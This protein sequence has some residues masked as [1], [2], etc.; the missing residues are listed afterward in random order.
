M[1]SAKATPKRRA[2]VITRLPHKLR[3][4]VHRARGVEAADGNRTLETVRSPAQEFALSGGG[5]DVQGGDRSPAAL[6]PVLPALRARL[7]DA[8]CGR[9]GPRRKCPAFG[10]RAP[11][12]LAAH[13]QEKPGYSLLALSAAGSRDGELGFENAGALPQRSTS[14]ALSRGPR[15]SDRSRVGGRLASGHSGRGLGMAGRRFPRLLPAAR[16]IKAFASHRPMP[17]RRRGPRRR[18]EGPSSVFARRIP[19]PVERRTWIVQ[20][21]LGCPVFPPRL[22]R[23]RTLGFA[24]GR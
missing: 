22:S 13:S 15:G 7:S 20:R 23:G 3:S 19:R 12:L 8:R 5:T 6:G 1:P 24:V 18:D 17:C 9:R 16:E 11:R 14:G 21:R 2:C 10:A 4:A